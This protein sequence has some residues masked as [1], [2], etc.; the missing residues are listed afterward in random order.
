MLPSTVCA[1]KLAYGYR[2]TFL[3]I[4]LRDLISSYGQIK[5]KFSTEESNG[6]G[7]APPSFRVSRL[8]DSHV[9][10]PNWMIFS[11]RFL[12]TTVV[13]IELVQRL[14]PRDRRFVY[15]ELPGH[16][17][18]GLSRGVLLP[19]PTRLSSDT[20]MSAL[21]STLLPWRGFCAAT[22]TRVLTRVPATWT[23]GADSILWYHAAPRIL[24][25]RLG[26]LIE[27]AVSI[28]RHAFVNGVIAASYSTLSMATKRGQDERLRISVHV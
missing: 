24:T 18:A 11:V 22:M 5:I 28:A 3:V 25:L 13:L 14:K 19:R 23:L 9:V 16:V 20:F 15:R 27:R 2:V 17:F 12:L 26:S 7:R 4:Q 10:V 6:L 8:V 21:R 1:S